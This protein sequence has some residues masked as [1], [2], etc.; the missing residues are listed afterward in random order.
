[1]DLRGLRQQ[2]VVGAWH[3][4]TLVRE[5]QRNKLCIYGN[6]YLEL[7]VLGKLFILTILKQQLVL[8]LAHVAPL[9]SVFTGNGTE[10]TELGI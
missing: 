4:R 10:N 1:V 8:S 7:L 9:E 5:M 2:Q 6:G 3:R